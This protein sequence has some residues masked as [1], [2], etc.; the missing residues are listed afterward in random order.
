MARKGA[1]EDLAAELAK[2]SFTPGK[3]HVPGLLALVV[4]G[5]DPA[6]QRAIK[7]LGQLG[8][9]VESVIAA[10]A[11]EADEAARARIVSALGAMA[12]RDSQPALREI[13]ARTSD[14]GVRVRRAAASAL[15]Q[16]GGDAARTALLARWDASDVSPD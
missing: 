14:P 6:S 10:V 1:S 11:A 9:H 15:G 8:A 13:V 7:A 5:V 3:A 12:R 16:I 4:A 2:P